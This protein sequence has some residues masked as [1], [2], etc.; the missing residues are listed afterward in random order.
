[1]STFNWAIIGTGNIAGAMAEA[2]GS[3]PGARRFAVASRSAGKAQKFAEHWG[4]DRPYA[5]YSD[6]YADPGVDIVY[7]ATPNACHKQNI[8]DALAAGKHVLC[9]KPLTLSP[10]DSIQ[11]FQFAE[12]SG[13]VLM[14]AL[15]TAFFPAMQKA[16][17]L[18]QSGSIGKP[19][20]LNAN[21]V[22]L[23]NPHSHPNLFDPDLGG[24]A[25]Q[26][27]GIYPIAAALLL[28]GPVKSSSSEVVIG[29]SGVDEMVAMSLAHENGTI[30]QVAFGFRAELP[31]A[32][33]VVGDMGEVEISDNFH[34]PQAVTLKTRDRSRSFDLPSIGK[35]YAHEAIAFQKLVSG[36]SPSEQ[37]W[38]ASFTV[39]SQR[40]LQGS[41]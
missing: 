28:V 24:G 25:S 10:E 17:E 7:V 30:S 9:E 41:Y 29:P 34:H 27:L 39:Q 19:R 16:V 32:V 1:M 15:W 21:F 22:S 37:L 13:L 2:L 35:G 12:R 38:P 26:D 5:D 11:C 8:L 18:V 14:E 36:G 20:Y 40:I 23:R 3:V 31:V 33:R 4:F 6:V